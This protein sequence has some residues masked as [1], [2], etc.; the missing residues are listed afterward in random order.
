V[1]YSIATDRLNLIWVMPAQGLDSNILLKKS[2]G[3]LAYAGVP[4][5]CSGSGAMKAANLRIFKEI[6]DIEGT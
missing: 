3:A 4:F 2:L 1:A 5:C 6:F